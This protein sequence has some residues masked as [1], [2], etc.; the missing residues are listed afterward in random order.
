MIG[1][2]AA[3]RELLTL[4]FYGLR[5]SELRRLEEKGGQLSRFGHSYGCELGE[6]RCHGGPAQSWVDGGVRCVRH[7][8]GE[9][10]PLAGLPLP[11]V[12]GDL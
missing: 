1:R 12:A 5:D 11:T 9:Q 4:V 2:V 3:V 8:S 7:Q 10:D 6:R